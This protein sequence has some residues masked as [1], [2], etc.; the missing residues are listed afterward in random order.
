M[1]PQERPTEEPELQL[2]LHEYD[3][4]GNEIRY[5]DRIIHN[6]YYLLII[7]FGVFAQG[8]LGF[9]RDGLLTASAT[10]ALSAGGA[11]IFLSFII[12]TYNER[13]LEAMLRRLEVAQEVSNNYGN[14]FQIQQ[15]LYPGLLNHREKLMTQEEQ[16]L[17]A[18]G[19]RFIALIVGFVA[20]GWVMLGVILIVYKIGQNVLIGVVVGLVSFGFTAVFCYIVL[21]RIEIN[22]EYEPSLPKI[23]LDLIGDNE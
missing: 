22:P 5:R 15:I 8:A 18:I 6:S 14:H 3:E 4:V 10:L 13:R 11:Y 12:Y 2:L 23:Y 16:D 7:I 1:A 19:P 9:I 17:R 20:S 21:D